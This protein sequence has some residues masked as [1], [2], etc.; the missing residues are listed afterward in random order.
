M[1]GGTGIGGTI[2]PGDNVP[3]NFTPRSSHPNNVFDPGY[4]AGDLRPNCFNEGWLR[5]CVLSCRAQH[6]TGVDAVTQSIAQLYGSDLL[7][8]DSRD[9]GDVGANQAGINNANE[10][11]AGRSC[12]DECNEQWYD[13][14]D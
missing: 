14:R 9:E 12:V 6:I 7:W 13:K 8:Q 1:Y 4:S 3:E 10:N 2:I 5:H 11:S